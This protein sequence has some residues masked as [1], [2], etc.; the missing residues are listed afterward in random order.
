M[1]D[2]ETD[3]G[4]RWYVVYTNPKQE[5]RAESNLSAWGIQTLY[6][7]IKKRRLNPFTNAPVYETAPLFPRYIFARFCVEKLFHKVCFT[8]GVH[9]IVCFNNVPT[10][11]ED[12][13]VE[14]IAAN[15]DEAGFAR[16]DEPFKV[17]DRLLIQSGP[18]K[19]LVGVFERQ[20]KDSERITLLL[21]AVSY[22]S[23]TVIEKA[24]V[25]KSGS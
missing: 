17:G 1:D 11:V 20:M 19:G 6:P 2:R 15:I 5:Q 3:A 18:L 22:Q 13:A 8:R 4:L 16:I 7:K 24:M 12:E 10:R 21:D 14:L 9:S 25:V 23:R